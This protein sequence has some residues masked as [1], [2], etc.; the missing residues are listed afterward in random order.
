LTPLEFRI[1]H[2]LAINVGRVVTS[3]RLVEHAWGY[4]GGES[5]LLKTHVSHI[6]H[7]LGMRRGESGYV[8]AVPWVGY[9]L[10]N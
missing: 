2:V 5:S 7:K 3:A 4:D 1:L 9:S 8:K 10:T 6:R